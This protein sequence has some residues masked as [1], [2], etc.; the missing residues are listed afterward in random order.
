MQRVLQGLLQERVSI[1]NIDL[2][3]E[4]LVDVGRVERDPAELV[5]RIRQK[6]GVAICN[7][8]R[9]QHDDLAVLSLDPR[10]ENRIL[11]DVGA[12]GGQGLLGVDPR[13]ADQLIKEITPLA[14]RMIRQGRAPV[15]LCAGPLRRA[16]ARLTQRT[17]AQL[18]V[19][20]VDE[21]PTRMSLSSF[22][23]VRLEP[24]SA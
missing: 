17:M 18:A 3:C 6:L 11:A 19:I 4:T 21:I 14:D 9:G 23:V 8:L 24:A 15:L 22:D 10:T 20:S 7:A 12:S 2:I 5:E 16:L 1:A 13:L